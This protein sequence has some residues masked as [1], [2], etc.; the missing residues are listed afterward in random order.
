MMQSSDYL[1]SSSHNICGNY[2]CN[3]NA[4]VQESFHF[5]T[6]TRPGTCTLLPGLQNACT[7]IK[8][9]TYFTNSHLFVDKMFRSSNVS[10]HVCTTYKTNRFWQSEFVIGSNHKLF[11]SSI[12]Q[13]TSPVRDIV[14]LD[15]TTITYN[16][17]LAG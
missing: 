5:M 6:G 16:Y 13:M 14:Y 3:S 1:S 8:T 17:W 11:F 7:Y 9:Q 2:K 10:R 4:N 12:T 15:F